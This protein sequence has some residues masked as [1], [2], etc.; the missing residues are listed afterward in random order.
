[1]TKITV[2]ERYYLADEIALINEGVAEVIRKF[3][4]KKLKKIVEKAREA[5]DK[6]DIKKMNKLSQL[7]PKIPLE[8]IEEIA[9]KKIKNYIIKKRAAEKEAIKVR[10]PE[11]IR[12]HITTLVAVGTTTLED[13]Q[14]AVEYIGT[15]VNWRNVLKSMSL[16]LILSLTLVLF[17]FIEAGF[18]SGSLLS[19]FFVVNV[20]FLI[21]DLIVNREKISAHSETNKEK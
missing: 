9:K 3:S 11:Q 20:V 8:Q 6:K 1:M 10:I 19:Y 14:K 2:L 7:A 18:I 21:Y 16:T 12:G 4:V 17:S 15:K 5:V 13:T